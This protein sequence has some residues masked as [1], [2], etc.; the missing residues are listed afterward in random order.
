M[1]GVSTCQ[2]QVRSQGVKIQ[3]VGVVTCGLPEPKRSPNSR[4]SISVSGCLFPR[5]AFERMCCPALLSKKSYRYGTSTEVILQNH[6]N[7]SRETDN[8]APS[9]RRISQGRRYVLYITLHH[10]VHKTARYVCTSYGIAH[11]G[12]TVHNKCIYT[13]RPHHRI[14]GTKPCYSSLTH[15]SAISPMNGNQYLPKP[16]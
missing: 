14:H 8:P 10:A 11:D 9:F 15:L 3:R 12:C 1:G 5:L 7:D 2:S 4:V 13:K 16:S 6:T